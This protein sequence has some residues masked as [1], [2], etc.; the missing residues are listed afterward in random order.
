MIVDVRTPVDFVEVRIEGAVLIDAT[1]QDLE[2]RLGSLDRDVPYV[3]YCWTGLKSADV[4]DL[5][6]ELGF[7]D[8]L[9]LEGG[10]DAW[11]AAR[12]PVVTG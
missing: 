2:E 5:M 8:V 1:A 4:S 6:G 9:E 12:K 10:L 7:K 3:L 11:I